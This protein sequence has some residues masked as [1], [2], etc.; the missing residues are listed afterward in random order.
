MLSQAALTVQQANRRAIRPARA[1]NLINCS[2]NDLRTRTRG[3]PTNTAD[4]PPL[5]GN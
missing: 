2:A 5:A 3:P 4:Q 1:I